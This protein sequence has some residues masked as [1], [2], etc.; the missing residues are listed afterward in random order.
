MNVQKAVKI[1]ATKSINKR[2]SQIQSSNPNKLVLAYVLTSVDVFREKQIHEYFEEYRIH[3][4]W[5]EWIVLTKIK[6]WWKEW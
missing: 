4:E 2:I 5:F 1:G 3:G 6:S